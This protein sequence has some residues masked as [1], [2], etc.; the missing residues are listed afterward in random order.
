MNSSDMQAHVADEVQKRMAKAAEEI[1]EKYAAGKG[2]KD[3][4]ETGPSGSAYK[5]AQESNR[6]ERR[7]QKIEQQKTDNASGTD[8]VF[9]KMN[10]T[11]D[12]LDSEGSDDDNE[13][14]G[15]R[16]KRLKE[17]RAQERQKVEDRGK[18]HGQYR[19]IVQDE[20]IKEMTSSDRVV[21]V[22]YHQD[23]PICEIMHHHME[24]LAQRHIETKFVKIDAAKAIF[25]VQKLAIRSMPTTML[26]FDGIANDKI[27]G[28]EGLC[29]DQPEGKE[30]EWPTIRLARLL[31]SKG[32]INKA[33]IVDDDE[34]EARE[35]AKF[36]QMRK[37][38][39][40]NF[41]ATDDAD[42]DFD[43]SD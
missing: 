12:D 9:T 35:K 1:G 40:V 17:I 10:Q 30:D 14:R 26:F 36:E 3:V 20:F 6:Q 15:I 2:G 11:E 7:M 21:C 28:F 24:K 41:S 33:N 42:D 18:G 25:F 4:S 22:F 5:E 31:A 29:E 27:I 16:D 34:I 37:K 8:S 23:A 38:A 32:S 39:Y 13:L 19:H 43:L